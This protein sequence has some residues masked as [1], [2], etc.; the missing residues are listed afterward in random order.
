MQNK[1]VDLEQSFKS[2]SL[3]PYY[4]NLMVLFEGLFN[5]HYFYG[6]LR[7]MRSWW[8]TPTLTSAV[9]YALHALGIAPCGAVMCT[10]RPVCTT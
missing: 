8:R 6:L 10:V 3:R 9:V 2:V 1:Y 7:S 5:Y 4:F